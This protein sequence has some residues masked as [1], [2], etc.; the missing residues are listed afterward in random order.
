MFALVSL[1][2]LTTVDSLEGKREMRLFPSPVIRKNY[3]ND[4]SGCH[5]EYQC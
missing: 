3:S 2:A 4:E 1:L 5:D